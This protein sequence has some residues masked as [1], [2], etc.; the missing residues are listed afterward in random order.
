ML[1]KDEPDAVDI[2]ISDDM[3]VQDVVEEVLGKISNMQ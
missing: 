3:T 2:D 1:G